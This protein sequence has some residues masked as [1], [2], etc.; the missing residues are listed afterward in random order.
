LWSVL[1][2]REIA[3]PLGRYQSDLSIG[4]LAF[5]PNGRVLASGSNDDDTVRLWDV[6]KHAES[7]PPH[8]SYSANNSFAF[9]PNGK[10]LAVGSGDVIRLFGVAA[11]HKTGPVLTGDTDSVETVAFSPDGRVLA[12]G[13]DDRTVR[14][15]DVATHREIGNALVG[16][17]GPVYSIAF[18]PDSKTVASYSGD[19]TMRLWDVASEVPLVSLPTGNATT[20]GYQELM[21]AGANGVLVS[22]G[23]QTLLWN[24]VLFETRT[25]L[26]K[27]ATVRL[28]ALLGGRN[29]T[30]A[31]WSSSLP[32]EP[33]H[34]TC[35]DH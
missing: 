4:S 30:H 32:G 27:T 16:H 5:S 7:G 15:W 9:S 10:L 31:E 21:A 12:S 17:T 25:S 2:N 35:T 29:L 14:L 33:Y 23:P 18:S 3:P 8:A 20:R 13:S 19:G 6:A 11:R 26:L 34:R 1:N 24:P 28:C 22:A